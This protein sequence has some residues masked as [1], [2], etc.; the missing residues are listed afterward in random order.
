M[1]RDG[2]RL[3]LTC[4]DSSK[5]ES[6]TWFKHKVP[7]PTLLRKPGGV[8]ILLS[9]SNIVF[10]RSVWLLCVSVKLFGFECETWILSHYTKWEFDQFDILQYHSCDWLGAFQRSQ[11]VKKSR[12][13][14]R[15]WKNN[16]RNSLA[17]MMTAPH[18]NNVLDPKISLWLMVL[19]VCNTRL[20]IKK[21]MS[22]K[23]TEQEVTVEE[24]VGANNDNKHCIVPLEATKA[25]VPVVFPKSEKSKEFR[26]DSP[27]HI[28]ECYLI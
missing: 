13:T 16:F 7:K 12:L 18:R 19:G 23:D 3:F 28:A 10:S 8:I 24:T 15:F 25:Y 11:I 4:A 6:L 1:T 17:R 27:L 14:K 5:L 26:S 22:T 20:L 2:C 21:C 9:V